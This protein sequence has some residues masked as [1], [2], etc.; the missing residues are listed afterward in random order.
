[1]VEKSRMVPILKGGNTMEVLTA[2]YEFGSEAY[3]AMREKG[4][5]MPQD[6]LDKLITIADKLILEEK[7]N[8]EQDRV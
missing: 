4:E 5:Q 7:K 8:A 6:L 2:A 1:M 3:W